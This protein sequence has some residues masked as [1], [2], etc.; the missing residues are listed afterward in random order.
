[1]DEECFSFCIREI[2][3]HPWPNSP[4]FLNDGLAA[5]ALAPQARMKHG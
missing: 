4:Q 5:F 3:V 1:M 2:H